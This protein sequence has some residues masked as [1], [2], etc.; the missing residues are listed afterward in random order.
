VGRDWIDEG[1]RQT[2]AREQQRQLAQERRRSQAATI[3]ARAA[4]LMRRLVAEVGAALDEYRQKTRSDDIEFEPLPHEGFSIRKASY[5][6]VYLECRP[7]YE[8]QVLYCNLS[9]TDREEG[10]NHQWAFNLHFTVIDSD[11]VALRH[12]DQIFQNAIAPAEFLLKQVLF[13]SSDHPL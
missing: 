10:E 6:R 3:A 11:V 7:S 9:R 12:G 8:G 1:L 5:P 13:P 4:E 2:P